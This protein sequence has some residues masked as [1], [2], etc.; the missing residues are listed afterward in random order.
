M[1]KTVSLIHW[2]ADEA[3]PLIDLMESAGYQVHYAGD[4][5]PIRM[6]ELRDID[7]V[8]AV[9][10][11]SR[12]PS[13]GKYW[14]A[15]VRSS[16]LKHLP[17]LFVDGDS[18]RVE[19]IRAAIP[20]AEYV[21]I[22]DLLATLKR[23]KPVANPVQPERMMAS[24]RSAVQ[25]LGIKAGSRVAVFDAPRD[26]PKVIGTLPEG[27]SFE[28]EPEDIAS[29]TLWFVREADTYLAGLRAMKKIAAKSK[30]W[31]LYPKQ[32]KGKTPT[33]ITQFVLREAAIK[34]GLVDY[35]VCAVD[36]T[37]TGFAL[38]VKK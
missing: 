37:W 8:A 35:K 29:V 38:A 7:P 3:R 34:V 12:M 4:Q 10:D 17:I 11:L 13:Y 19:R 1:K 14:A 15:E 27:A 36:E 9:V 26:Y 21:S 32:R 28:E 20:D 22:D 16:K 5:K 23:A 33:G 25:K 18:E 31:V 2:K 24:T 30:L 6:T